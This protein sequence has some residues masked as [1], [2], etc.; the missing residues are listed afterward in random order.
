[1][2]NCIIFEDK[3]DGIRLGKRRRS[4]SPTLSLDDYLQLDVYRTRQTDPGKKRVS[5]FFFI[6]VSIDLNI[7][8]L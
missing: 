2:F 5:P 3:L 4:A 8:I 1:M 7:D 6:T